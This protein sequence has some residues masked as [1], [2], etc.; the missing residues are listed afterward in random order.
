MK[1]SLKFPNLLLVAFVIMC[2]CDSINEDQPKMMLEEIGFSGDL[3]VSDGRDF[4]TNMV[5]HA[6]SINL[7]GF[8]QDQ[9]LFS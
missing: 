5:E 3:P 4:G 6:N 1:K 9:Y 7:S 8:N 2:G